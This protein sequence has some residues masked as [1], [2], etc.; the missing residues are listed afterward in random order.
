MNIFGRS[1]DSGRDE[2]GAGARAGEGRAKAPRGVTAG[3]RIP[4][5]AKTGLEWATRPLRGRKVGP[6]IFGTRNRAP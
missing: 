5:Q 6:R 3:S 1:A 2:C 4:T